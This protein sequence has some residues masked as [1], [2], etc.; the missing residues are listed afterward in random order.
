MVRRIAMLFNAAAVRLVVCMLGATPCTERSMMQ[1]L[2][3]RWILALALGVLLLEF[4]SFLAVHALGRIAPDRRL[5]RFVEAQL[6]GFDDAAVRRH[7]ETAYDAELGWDNPAGTRETDTNVA[8]RRWTATYAAGGQR[9]S[10]MDAAAAG[11]PAAAPL[12]AAYGDSTT[13]GDEVDDGEAWPCLLERALGR[14]V[15]NHGVGGFGVDQ[16]LLKLRRHWASGRVAPVTILGI[17]SD[18]A[19]QLLNRYRPFLVPGTR[20][21]LA[22]KPAHRER[23]GRIVAL[24]NPWSPDVRTVAGVRALAIGVAATDY[25]AERSG[26][27]LPQFPYVLQAWKAGLAYVRV[28]AAGSDAARSAWDIP[29]A[30]AVLLQLLRDFARDA[31]RVGTRPVLLFIPSVQDWSRGRL[32]ADYAGFLQEDLARAGI[33]LTVID[34][35]SREFDERRF[36]VSP[37]RGHPS[38]AGNEVIARVLLERWPGPMAGQAG[39]R[40]RQG[41]PL[42]DSRRSSV[43]PRAPAT[44]RL[45]RPL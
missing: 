34:V 9:V 27:V 16:A 36:N 39:V 20:T 44:S 37:Y 7:L 13:H 31:R 21:K 38:A 2:A 15:E 28:R 41:A 14:R 25:W 11:V 4:L 45:Y 1:R 18:D 29:E 26:R 42:E 5:D 8:G 12:A 10:C 43:L 24:P 40:Q 19:A 33:E 30:R 32:P 6:D 17:Y 3:R 23:E 22:F 35:A